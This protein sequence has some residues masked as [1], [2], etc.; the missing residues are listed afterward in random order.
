[1]SPTHSEPGYWQGSFRQHSV[2]DCNIGANGSVSCV[3]IVTDRQFF[4]GQC[5]GKEQLYF[6][7]KKNLRLVV[8]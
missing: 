2:T 8:A 4:F 3:D 6:G 7:E 5:F 1:M